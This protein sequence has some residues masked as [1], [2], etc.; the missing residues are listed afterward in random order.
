LR[1]HPVPDYP[2][3]KRDSG[4]TWRCCWSDPQASFVTFVPSIHITTDMR[5]VTSIPCHGPFTAYPSH[6][7]E[8]S[9]PSFD[10]RKT[11]RHGHEQIIRRK[12]CQFGDGIPGTGWYK[13]GLHEQTENRAG[14]ETNVGVPSGTPTIGLRNRC[15][16]S[17][18]RW[19][20]R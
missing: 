18:L 20:G 15:S 1:H 8:S 11:S 9:I 19:R 14:T 5:Y 2:I 17:E 12:W 3:S 10:Q 16:T 7:P 13:S 6:P 4:V